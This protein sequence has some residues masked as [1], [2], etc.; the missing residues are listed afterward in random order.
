MIRVVR[1]HWDRSR[2]K[3]IQQVFEDQRRK[4][5]F[6]NKN[7]SISLSKWIHDDTSGVHRDLLLALVASANLPYPTTTPA[8]TQRL[9]A[10]TPRSRVSSTS[11]WRSD[12]SS[13]ESTPVI[14]EATG[15]LSRPPSPRSPPL[16]P[17]P[18]DSEEEEQVGDATPQLS[19][20]PQFASHPSFDDSETLARS[21]SSTSMVPGSSSDSLN[22]S[23]S[24][25]EGTRGHKSSSSLSF[26]QRTSP[27]DIVPR[28]DSAGS[29]PRDLAALR[30]T[31]PIAPSRRRQM[32]TDLLNSRGASEDPMSPP[33]LSSRTPG[34]G[35]TSPMFGRSSSSGELD[36]V[37]SPNDLASSTGSSRPSDHRRESSGSSVS[38]RR[39]TAPLS[40]PSSPLSD[41]HLS[42]TSSPPSSIDTTSYHAPPISPVGD[43][44][45]SACS[46]NLTSSAYDFADLASLQNS[47]AD[48]FSSGNDSSPEKASPYL[49]RRQG[50]TT[51]IGS[52]G[53]S[54][55]GSLFFGEALGSAGASAFPY[56][57]GRPASTVITPEQQLQILARNYHEYGQTWGG[58]GGCCTRMIS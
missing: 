8:D 42:E 5:T 19:S 30:H 45:S 52:S 10:I 25:G 53:G 47:T 23:S 15:E 14:L 26:R 37:N 20:F 24:T 11:S 13:K 57:G 12:D 35:N 51:S 6:G 2:F 7:K 43:V 41:S 46:S 56:S 17:L 18:P 3:K 33:L 34:S 40:L 22:S 36:R 21:P 4:E 50:S 49:F 58:G 39:G 54:R 38:S 29:A 28:P 44:G 48:Y 27:L 9:E 55:P 31:R 1:A 32:S 16:V